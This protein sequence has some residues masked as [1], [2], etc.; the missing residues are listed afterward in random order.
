MHYRRGVVSAIASMSLETIACDFRR[1]SIINDG[2]RSLKVVHWDGDSQTIQYVHL[3]IENPLYAEWEI[4]FH[5]VLY[6]S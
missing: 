5:L 6:S 3:K 4:S 2:A 1:D